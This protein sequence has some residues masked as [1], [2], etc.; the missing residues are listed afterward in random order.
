MFLGLPGATAI[1]SL[2]LA[3]MTGVSTRL[4]DTS[5]FMLAWSAEAN[6]SAG[7]PFSIWVTRAL[8]PPKL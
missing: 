1:S 2:F 4:F 5:L 7:A 3:K 6:T 8:D